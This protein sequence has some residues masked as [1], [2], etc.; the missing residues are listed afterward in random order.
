MQSPIP[1]LTQELRALLVDL[2]QHPAFPVLLRAIQAPQLPRFR[3]S[4]AQ[5]PD[6]AFASWA[7]VSGKRDQHDA[8]LALL[9]GQAPKGDES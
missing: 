5:Q 2:R 1:N 6:Q 7:Y 3:T 9:T 8:W 4:Q